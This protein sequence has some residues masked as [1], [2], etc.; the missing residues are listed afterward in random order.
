MAPAAPLNLFKLQAHRKRRLCFLTLQQSN[1]GVVDDGSLT[2]LA[3][4]NLSVGGRRT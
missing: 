2:T 3:S 4:V 1:G